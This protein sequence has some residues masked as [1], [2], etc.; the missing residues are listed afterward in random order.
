MEPKYPDIKVQLSGEDGN[1]FHILGQV[2]RAL[3]LSGVSH[4]E[5]VAYQNES[6]ASDYDDLL[7]TAMRWVTVL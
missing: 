7:A 4:E 6:M 5:T 2:S 3:R 1:A